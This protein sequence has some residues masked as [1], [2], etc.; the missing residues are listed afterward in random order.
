MNK[1]ILNGKNRDPKSEQLLVQW[2]IL[3]FQK[4]TMGWGQQYIFLGK[5]D[6]GHGA[7]THTE[8]VASQQVK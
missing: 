4:D 6:L 5:P 7:C 1:Y 2:Y 3:D 8:L